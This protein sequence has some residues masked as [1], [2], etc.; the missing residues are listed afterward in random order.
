MWLAEKRKMLVKI[1]WRLALLIGPSQ[2]WWRGGGGLGKTGKIREGGERQKRVTA[3]AC[4]AGRRG[5]RSRR[6]YL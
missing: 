5:G 4:G 6:L 3:E 1:L 2:C